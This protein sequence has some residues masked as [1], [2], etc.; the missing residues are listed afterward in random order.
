MAVNAA[1]RAMDALRPKSPSPGSVVPAPLDRTEAPAS[2]LT[3]Q[4]TS[5]RPLGEGS[6]WTALP[7][8][9]VE[10]VVSPSDGS[11]W[12]LAAVGSGPNYPLVHY[13]SGTWSTVPGNAKQIAISPN[14]TTLYAVNSGGGIWAYNISAQTWSGMAGG[15]NYLTV[16]TDGSLYALSNVAI[17]ADYPI[18]HY[19]SGSWASVPGTGVAIAAS[20]DPNT[21]PV[22]GG[23]VGPNGFWIFNT[24]GNLYY[25]IPGVG[26]VWAPGNV[27][28][29]APVTGGLFAIGST[30]IYFYDLAAH[31]WLPYSGTGVYVNASSTLLYLIDSTHNIWQAPWEIITVT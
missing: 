22:T 29:L 18:W 23:E 8:T 5:R 7:G 28:S 3:A 31:S 25:Y 4:P 14:G 6:N 15:A 27:Q 12:A 2:W 21:Y 26:Y 13:S 30:S 11:L 19:A 1:A 16:A 10:A 9:V 17:G 20:W 24:L